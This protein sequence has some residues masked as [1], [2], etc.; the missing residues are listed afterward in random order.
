MLIIMHLS[1]CC[2]AIAQSLVG[3]LP[4]Q[5]FCYIALTQFYA[6]PLESYRKS[7]IIA[8]WYADIRL[9]QIVYEPCNID[10][11]ANIRYAQGSMRPPVLLERG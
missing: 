8:K 9:A 7:R 2:L 6:F 1:G 10:K 11:Q 4:T 3:F 5:S